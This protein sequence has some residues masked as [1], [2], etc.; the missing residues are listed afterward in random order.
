M[1]LIEQEGGGGKIG[2]RRGRGKTEGKER[3]GGM[4]G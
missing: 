1:L 3:R 2:R 4:G